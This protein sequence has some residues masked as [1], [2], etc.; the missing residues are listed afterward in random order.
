MNRSPWM[1]KK[2]NGFL[3]T[4]WWSVGKDEGWEN[5][6]LRAFEETDEI[7]GNLG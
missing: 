3:Q 4:D 2:K 6:V 5:M 1:G 7:A